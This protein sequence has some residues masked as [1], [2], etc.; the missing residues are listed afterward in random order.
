MTKALARHKAA[1][2]VLFAAALLERAGLA[3]PRAL[4]VAETL[5]DADLMGHD[6]HG[7]NL[8]GPYLGEIEKD[9]MRRTGEPLTLADRGPALAWDGQR[10]PG[11]WLVRKAMDLAAERARSFGTAT[12]VIRR[13]HHIACLA[14]YLKRAT[15][16]GLVMLLACSDP[17]GGSVA[18][19]GGRRGV[20]T[21]NPIAAGWPTESAP[22]LLDVSM[23]YTTNGLTGRLHKEGLRL[24]HPWLLDEDGRPTD[25]PSVLFDGRQGALLPLGGIEAG[26][27]G[28]ALGLLVEA[29]TSALAGHGR[30]DPKEGWGA[31]VYLQM[32]DPDAFGG[33]AAFAREAQW[34]AEACRAVPPRPGLGPVRL[35]GERG[36]ALRARQI[37]E[38]VA[39]HPGIMPQ[40]APWA[41]RFGIPVPAALP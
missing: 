37:R 32:I 19:H 30:A 1:D 35:P 41:E 18:P 3:R 23:S 8:L 13:S 9:S 34:L 10:L 12:I 17:N 11:P 36:L 25:D 14:A 29:L 33:R 6:T 39:L 24:P 15:D 26:H 28:F 22:V 4:A 20:Y 40:I 21:P 31:S 5:V 38:G 7:L 2:L 16:R 27:K